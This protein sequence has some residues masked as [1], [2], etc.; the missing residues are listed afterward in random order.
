[1]VE[2]DSPRMND[3]EAA[4]I[5]SAMENT[6]EGFVTI[7][8][9]HRIVFFNKAAEKI[10]GCNRREVLGHDLDTILSPGC[11]PD[12]RGAVEKYIKTGK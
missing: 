8:K 11:S 12:H 6:N 10:F 4:V 7:D 1:M 2:I 9:N 3:M 5:K